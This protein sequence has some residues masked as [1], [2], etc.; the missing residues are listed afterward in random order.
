VAS[1]SAS[2][3][4][5]IRALVRLDRA[6]ARLEMAIASTA[7]AIGLGVSLFTIATR[8]LL[9][10]TAEWVL[11]L[12][13]ELLV[14]ASVYGSGALIGRDRHLMV[15]IVVDRLPA[16]AQ[17]SVARSVQMI[18]A[19]LCGFLAE[20]GVTAAGQV[21]R[22][23]LHIPELFNLS[24]AVPLGVAS[25]GLALWSLHFWI[26]LLSWTPGRPDARVRM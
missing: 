2:P 26:S 25:A 23:G 11:E 21:A 8:A 1:E 17:R 12:P 4:R 7:L 10:A 3:P 22:A 6:I 5:W 15:D 20:R 9:I 19:V 24:S 13:M 16:G 18:L 14:V